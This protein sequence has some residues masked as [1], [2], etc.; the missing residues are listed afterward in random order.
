MARLKTLITSLIVATSLLLGSA[1]AMAQE[2]Q[3]IVAVVNDEVISGYDLVQRISLTILMSGFR[4][5]AQ[6]RQQL[7]QPTLRRLIEERL[8]LQEAARFNLTVSDIEMNKAVDRLEKSNNIPSGQI[9]SILERRRIDMD[10]LLEQIRA[11]LAW[12]KVV[13]RRIVPRVNV[14]EEEIEAARKKMQAN[15]GKDEYFLSEIFLPVDDQSDEARIRK[16]M[17]D[18]R[19]QLKKGAPFP[20]VATQFSQGT[21]AAK[22]GEIGW[23]ML[24]DLDP[25]IAQEVAKTRKG[26]VTS[27]IRTSEGYYLVAVRNARKILQKTEDNAR[28]E[29]SQIVIPMKPTEKT[30]SAKSQVRL[31]N[32]ISKFVDSCSYLPALLSEFGVRGSGKMGRVELKN[33]PDNVKALVKDLKP[34]QASAPF[35]DKDVYRIF[36]VC[37]RQEQ[38]V[39]SDSDEAIRQLIGVKRI[40][41]RARRYLQDLQRDATIE[42]R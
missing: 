1:G 37:G 17:N 26:Q 3:K 41:A 19:A 29:L 22:G 2:V 6:T 38:N 34:G 36:V 35:L 5:S 9:D 13:R 28:L 8:R 30:G 10:T 39:Q 4:D 25:E 11:S 15:R 16:L 20:R 27:A 33:M 31:V 42:T 23:T 21:T 32:S 12:D 18:I 7:V 24:E 40:E 14:T